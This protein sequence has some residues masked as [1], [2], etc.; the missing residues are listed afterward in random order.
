M[1][2]VNYYGNMVSSQFHSYTAKVH[3]Y[4]VNVYNS[5]IYYSM[6][7]D[8]VQMAYHLTKVRLEC[9]ILFTGTLFSPRVLTVFRIF[10][11]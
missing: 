6:W 1:L 3:S 7:K 9:F 4:T 5:F 2:T 10:V 11:S 8:N